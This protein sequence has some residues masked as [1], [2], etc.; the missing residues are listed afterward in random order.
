MGTTDPAIVN[1]FGVYTYRGEF[2]RLVNDNC[3]WRGLKAQF[4]SAIYGNKGGFSMMIP[5]ESER[6]PEGSLLTDIPHEIPFSPTKPQ[7]DIVN[8][9]D[10]PT[11]WFSSVLDPKLKNL[12][13]NVLLVLTTYGY[14]RLSVPMD[15]VAE[16]NTYM[17]FTLLVNNYL[18]TNP[19]E[20]KGLA[21]FLANPESSGKILG[22][23]MLYSVDRKTTNP[24]NYRFL[25]ALWTR[26]N[27]QV[28]QN[29]GDT[30]LDKVHG[31]NVGQSTDQKGSR[32]HFVVEVTQATGTGFVT[33]QNEQKLRIG[34]DPASLEEIESKSGEKSAEVKSFTLAELEKLGERF[35]E[36]CVDR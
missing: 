19:E 27:Q 31:I 21:A 10:R 32:N 1:K 30:S 8:W 7:V 26:I 20:G 6:S 36:P 14:W 18:S 35:L 2:T 13:S 29:R 16:S 11:T 25:A 9:K 22:Y 17:D 15:Y 23:C 3:E 33:Y 24:F 5:Q 34:L 28:Q 12:R 4:V